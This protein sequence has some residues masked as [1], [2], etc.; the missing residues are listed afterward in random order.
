MVSLTQDLGP[1]THFKFF[2]N[3]NYQ[4]IEAPSA[5]KDNLFIPFTEFNKDST[6]FCLLMTFPFVPLWPQK[7][8]ELHA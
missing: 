6:C 4:P 8:S 7:S 1:N 5:I 2:E 3:F